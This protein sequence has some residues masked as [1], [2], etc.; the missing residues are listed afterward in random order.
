MEED[1][2]KESG[3]KAQKS[4]KKEP[5]VGEDKGKVVVSVDNVVKD[6]LKWDIEGKEIYF[7]D[8]VEKFLELPEDIVK[9]LSLITRQRYKIAKSAYNDAVKE[10]ERGGSGIEY[11]SKIKVSGRFASATQ[12][13]KVYDQKKG[14]HQCYKRPDEAN[15]ALSEGYRLA[16][17]VKT[18]NSDVGSVHYVGTHGEPELILFEIPEEE[19]QKRLKKA[20]DLSRQRVEAVSTEGLMALGSAGQEVGENKASTEKISKH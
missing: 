2:L 14:W 20:G 9:E 10:K 7:E 12:K 17:D 18:F 16:K 4:T 6:V 3:G 13:L 15:M 11:L 8:E 19:F 1:I 5:K